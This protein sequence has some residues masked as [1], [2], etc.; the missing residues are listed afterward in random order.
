MGREAWDQDS[1]A[2]SKDTHFVNWTLLGWVPPSRVRGDDQ[3]CV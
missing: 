2:D 1:E 3:S